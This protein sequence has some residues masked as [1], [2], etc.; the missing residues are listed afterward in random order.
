M[1]LPSED[2]G[3]NSVSLCSQQSLK[4]LLHLKKVWDLE[5]RRVKMGKKLM[6]E[7]K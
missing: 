2:T 5:K 6:E 3:F 7:K 4:H 1:N